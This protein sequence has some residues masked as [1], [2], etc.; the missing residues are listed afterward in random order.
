MARLV[1]FS[2]LT[3]IAVALACFYPLGDQPLVG[4]LS[5]I[6]HSPLVQKKVGALNQGVEKRAQ[7]AG[8]SARSMWQKSTQI[9]S[10]GTGAPHSRDTRRDMNRD[11]D[12]S[13][14]DN[15]DNN[16]HEGGA[17]RPAARAEHKADAA[18]TAPVTPVAETHREP[19][20][21]AQDNLT[22]QDRNGLNRL[23]QDKLRQGS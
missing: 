9:K 4:H 21:P 10:H 16:N 2:G 23:L 11:N 15:R 5:E 12:N 22:D 14:S 17:K 20:R 8:E 19:V 7:R 13:D 3:V 6:Y 18:P 1:L